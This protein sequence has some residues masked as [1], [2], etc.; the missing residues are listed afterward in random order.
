MTIQSGLACITG[1][2]GGALLMMN[3]NWDCYYD[4]SSL[5]SLWMRRWLDRDRG[6]ESMHR[7]LLS[8]TVTG[9]GYRKGDAE[10]D[11]SADFVLLN[12]RPL[13]PPPLAPV[14]LS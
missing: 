13:Y 5:I 1:C 14:F 12:I 3:I 8:R 6:E 11:K 4:Y 7:C 2:S 9:S 10:V